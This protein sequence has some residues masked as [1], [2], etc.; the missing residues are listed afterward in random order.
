MAVDTNGLYIPSCSSTTGI[1]G[2]TLPVSFSFWAKMNSTAGAGFYSAFYF[3]PNSGYFVTFRDTGAIMYVRDS[4]PAWR[5]VTTTY[6]T[7][8]EWNHWAGTM[9][10]NSIH[11]YK[12]G[13]EVGTAGTTL[14]A[15][16]WVDTAKFQ[17][18]CYTT[19]KLDCSLAEL[20]IFGKVLTTD[21][22][23]LL[24]QRISR[25]PLQISNLNAYWPMDDLSVGLGTAGVGLKDYGPNGNN[26]PASANGLGEEF[27][28]AYPGGVGGS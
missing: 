16:N 17:L 1:W 8:G 5:T 2:A 21:D 18:G 4:T 25:S 24:K 27:S 22:R 12:N 23:T 6:P 3:G 26:F 19:L 20:A 14:T 28:F 15:I 7:V 13:G 10:A 9:A 11:F